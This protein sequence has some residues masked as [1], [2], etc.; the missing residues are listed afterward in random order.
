MLREPIK[1]VYMPI[2]V[3]FGLMGFV[4]AIA[5]SLMGLSEKSFFHMKDNIVN[6]PNEGLLINCIGLLLVVFG[7][8][9][10]YLVSE[11]GYKRQA[12]PEDAML[13]TGSE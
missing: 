2:H 4:L 3:F 10:V 13:L 8:L 11:K 7:S 1:E 9:V 12:L 6:L 5:A